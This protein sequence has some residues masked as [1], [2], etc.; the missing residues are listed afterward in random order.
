MTQCR[1]DTLFQ[2][3]SFYGKSFYLLE[4]LQGEKYMKSLQMYYMLAQLYIQTMSQWH[5]LFK[6]RNRLPKLHNFKQLFDLMFLYIG[7]K[8]VYKKNSCCGISDSP[9]N[10]IG[11]HN[12]RLSQW[13]VVTMTGCHNDRLSQWQVVTM[14][15]CHNDP[16]SQW[17]I[18]TMKHCHNDIFSQWH[19]VTMTR[20]HIEILSQWHVVTMTHCH[21]DMLSQCSDLILVNELVNCPFYAF[22]DTFWNIYWLTVIMKL[23]LIKDDRKYSKLACI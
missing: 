8:K 21:N 15:G 22:F 10:I 17:H 11:C 5:I 3:C 2:R 20:C 16:L 4:S 1:N 9:S 14:T 6:Y 13:Q 12:D 23:L 19:V 7:I 18:V